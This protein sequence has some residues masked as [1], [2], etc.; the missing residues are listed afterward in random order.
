M[1]RNTAVFAVL[2]VLMTP[3]G[4]AQTETDVPTQPLSFG[5]GMHFT[6]VQNGEFPT[7]V[8]ARLWIFNQ[9]GLEVDAFTREGNPTITLR[10]FYKLFDTG[11]VSLL[12]GGGVAFFSNGLSFD[13]TL[14]GAVGLEVNLGSNLVF[15]TEVGA[16]LGSSVAIPVTAGAGIYYYF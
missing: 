13:S 4:W 14:Q 3:L 1:R 11:L 7:G 16:L 5:A 15:G 6:A 12:M 10:T 8:S 9:Y 2:V